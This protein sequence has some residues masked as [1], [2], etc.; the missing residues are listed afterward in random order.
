LTDGSTALPQTPGRCGP[1]RESAALE[2]ATYCS[3]SSR[4]NQAALHPAYNSSY[5]LPDT[6][7]AN[8]GSRSNCRPMAHGCTRRR[9]AGGEIDGRPGSPCR[10]RS[11]GAACV[12]YGGTLEL[13]TV[14]SHDSRAVPVTFRSGKAI[15]NHATTISAVTKK[16]RLPVAALRSAPFSPPVWFFRTCNASLFIIKRPF[17]RPVFGVRFVLPTVRVYAAFTAMENAVRGCL[18]TQKWPWHK[19]RART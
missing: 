12:P 13:A 7:L 14:C 16:A 1:C 5:L 9:H 10:R 4:A 8:H 2:L 19:V 18:D 6:L 17:R 15:E 3:Q 11:C